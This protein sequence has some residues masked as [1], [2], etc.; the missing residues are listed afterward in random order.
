MTARDQELLINFNVGWPGRKGTF[1]DTPLFVS[2]V[3]IL[4][5]LICKSI[6]VLLEG[7]GSNASG[8]EHDHTVMV[9]LNFLDI[10]MKPGAHT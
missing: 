5:K 1:A 4:F 3:V 2:G 9:S 6:S 10:F 7:V 8:E